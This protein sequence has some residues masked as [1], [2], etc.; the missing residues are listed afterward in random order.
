LNENVIPI[1]IFQEFQKPYSIEEFLNP[2]IID[3]LEV[4]NNG[5]TVNGLS[6]TVNISN[7]SCDSPAKA[8]VLNV[9][10][11]NAYFGRTLCSEEGAYLEHRMT[12]PGLDATLRTDEDFRCKKDEDYNKGNSPLVSLPIN[13]INTVVLDYMHNVC[14]GVVKKLI[15]FWVKGNKQVRLEKDKKDKINNELKNYD[16]MYLPRYVVYPGCWMK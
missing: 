15:E 16:L 3:L 7:I 14:L 12:Y 4:L 5:L 13:I 11:H 1:G 6:F 9:K 2:L 8:F 10:G